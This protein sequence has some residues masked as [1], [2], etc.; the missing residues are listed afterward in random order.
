MRT[1]AIARVK[2]FHDSACAGCYRRA[3]VLDSNRLA[4]LYECY[5]NANRVPDEVYSLMAYR[6]N[7]HSSSRLKPYYL[8]AQGIEYD[9]SSDGKGIANDRNGLMERLDWGLE[10]RDVLAR[11]SESGPLA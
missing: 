3:D 1:G 7:V 2:L 11:L 10:P 8:P 6:R 5:G 4:Y 9:F